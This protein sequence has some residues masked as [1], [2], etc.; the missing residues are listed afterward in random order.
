MLYLLCA[1]HV[2]LNFERTCCVL[3]VSPLPF[4]ALLEAFLALQGA[5]LNDGICHFCHSYLCKIGCLYLAS[6]SQKK[7]LKER[8]NLRGA[9]S[10]YML[11]TD[12]ISTDT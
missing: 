7:H 10:S 3:L 9:G 5:S 1:S 11:K 2:G 4:K 8:T 12:Y 6:L